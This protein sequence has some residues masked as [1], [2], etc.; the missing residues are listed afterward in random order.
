M[1]PDTPHLQEQRKNLMQL[2]FSPTRACFCVSFAA[3]D[4]L[5]F[6]ATNPN[7]LAQ[8]S[9]ENLTYSLGHQWRNG[10][11]HQRVLRDFDCALLTTG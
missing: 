11:T 9:E 1:Y 8:F 3:R 6:H 4:P 7:Y 10:I 5:I 2:I